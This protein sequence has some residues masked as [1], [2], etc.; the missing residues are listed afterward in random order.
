MDRIKKASVAGMFYPSDREEL[1]SQLKDFEKNNKKD[2]KL[3][4]RALIVPH[5]GYVYSGQLASEGF[6]YL[7]KAK[8]VFI[9]APSHHKPLLKP[10]LSDFDYWYTPIGVI[11]VNQAINNELVEKFGCEYVNEAFEKEHAVEVQVPFL[12]YLDKA[13]SI[14]PILSNYQ[15]FEDIYKIIEAYYP[16]EDNAFVISTDLSHFHSKDEAEKLDD[17]TA[18]M[19]EGADIDRF[20]HEQACG[21]SGICAL[22]NFA[23]EQDFSLIRVGMTNSAAATGDEGRVVGYGSWVL[24]EKSKSE[25]I[26]EEFSDYVLKLCRDSIKAGLNNEERVIAENI[27]EV[28]KEFGASFVTLEI[29]GRLRGCIGSVIAH[30]PLLI[31]LLQHAYDSAFNDNR[32]QPLAAEEFDK[33][34]IFVSLLSSPVKM[35]FADENY[36]LAQIV[37]YKDGIIIKDGAHQA[38]YLPSV[39]E[40]LPDKK[41]FLN[42]LKV[43]AGLAPDYFS[44]SFE[45]WRFSTVYIKEKNIE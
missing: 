24:A 30:Q 18:A 44:K 4:S 39:W 31:D 45:A 37:P 41:E 6:Q 20:S 16:D 2:Y 28:F 1:L 12:Q 25:F 14:V 15:N 9:I 7:R 3:S 26:K 29:D 8:N 5:A 13:Q 42:S 23:R 27:P 35:A 40:Q 17:I 19:I 22:V 21:S 38:V 36:L 11:K 43:K 34:K 32:F 33:I 10:A